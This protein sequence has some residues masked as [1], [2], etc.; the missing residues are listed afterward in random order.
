MGMIPYVQNYTTRDNTTNLEDVGRGL[1]P[2]WAIP[3]PKGK[4]GK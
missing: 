4:Y 2:T 1:R 3:K